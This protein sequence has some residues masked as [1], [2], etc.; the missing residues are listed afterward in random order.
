MQEPIVNLIA[1]DLNVSKA[2]RDALQ[3]P[4]KPADFRQLLRRE[5]Q[6]DEVGY[7]LSSDVSEYMAGGREVR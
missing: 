7:G 2:F 6:A 5:S 4:F 1:K 3:M